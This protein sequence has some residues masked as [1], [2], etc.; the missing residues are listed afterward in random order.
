MS[1]LSVI[2]DTMK[3][4]K[5]FLHDNLTPEFLGS[6][7]NAADNI[8]ALLR[9]PGLQT[10][11]KNALHEVNA[12]LTKANQNNIVEKISEIMLDVQKILKA[13]DPNAVSSIINTIK[14]LLDAA[15]KAKLVDNVIKALDGVKSLSG[16]VDVANSLALPAKFLMYG[17]TG[18][19]L[20]MALT[21]GIRAFLSR[22]ND[23][24]LQESIDHLVAIN[25]QQ[26]S[27]MIEQLRTMAATY[28]LQ[29]EI[30]TRSNP[31]TDLSPLIQKQAEESRRLLIVLY[32]M[33]PEKMELF[34]RT[35][36]YAER[37]MKTFYQKPEHNKESVA[38]YLNRIGEDNN[39]DALIK[40]VMHKQKTI[41]ISAAEKPV[42]TR[43]EMNY[44]LIRRLYGEE[45]I[46]SIMKKLVAK[47]SA[48]GGEALFYSVAK[49]TIDVVTEFSECMKLI[50]QSPRNGISPFHNTAWAHDATQLFD[51]YYQ[52][53]GAEAFI[54]NE[55]QKSRWDHLFQNVAPDLTHEI[56][57][58][59]QKRALIELCYQFAP[60][61]YA[62]YNIPQETK[63]M[64]LELGAT[65][66]SIGGSIIAIPR[67]VPAAICAAPAA[68]RN[69]PSAV[70][71]AM[72]FENV[73]N[74]AISVKE[75]GINTARFAYY[76]PI[77]FV[78]KTG[79][80][81]LGGYVAGLAG[82]KLV[83]GL[84]HAPKVH[85]FA[86]PVPS[87]IPA[88]AGS[89]TGG[90]VATASTA[91]S[92]HSESVRQV[93]SGVEAE[94]KARELIAHPSIG[95]IDFDKIN[96]YLEEAKSMSF[97]E[98][99]DRFSQCYEYVMSAQ[100]SRGAMAPAALQANVGLFRLPARLPV[101]VNGMAFASCN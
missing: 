78:E 28:L 71:N 98:F 60:Y 35:Q 6:I 94:A 50:F 96:A 14:S 8:N 41:S 67:A 51:F 70:W 49:N 65:A 90:V 36:V 33:S 69:A 23:R 31:T 21:Q 57:S 42:L 12:L 61:F 40:F 64:I 73:K 25:T 97:A 87:G 77:K 55:W 86:A 81:V 47:F 95:E 13:V 3:E 68:I 88:V 83:A 29:Y 92:V 2:R 7:R 37:L 79:L 93:E 17:T 19:L 20:G 63:D 10:D 89:A 26:L 74:A 99:H 66:A 5:H 101:E 56:T 16:L 30:A 59:I 100:V 62:P 75:A 38:Q 91:I 34:G 9:D 32:P 48:N 43:N 84:Q 44:E 45:L 18:A 15:D 4:I 24:Q 52:T 39:Y 27:V 80:A 22:N 76:H 85:S 54:A 82:G 53:T 46:D 72:S 58:L 1:D 11:I